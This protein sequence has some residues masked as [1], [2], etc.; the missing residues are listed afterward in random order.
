[1]NVDK[2]IDELRNQLREFDAVTLGSEIQMADITL[3]YVD[4]LGA[5]HFHKIKYR[6]KGFEENSLRS[7]SL[8]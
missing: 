5:I 3:G 8:N 1:M 6:A 4:I 2:W 7:P